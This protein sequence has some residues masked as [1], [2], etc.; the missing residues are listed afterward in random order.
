MVIRLSRF[1]AAMTALVVLSIVLACSS[2]DK[3]DGEAVDGNLTVFPKSPPPEHLV[4]YDARDEDLALQYLLV[5]LQG[6]VNRSEPHIYLDTSPYGVGDTVDHEDF[7]L[8]EMANHFGITY[9]TVSSAEELM[10]R[11]ADEVSGIVITDPEM[12][13]TLNTAVM[14]AGQKDALIAAPELLDW[15][16]SWHLPVHDDL[17]GVWGSNEDLYR[18]AFENLWPGCTREILAYSWPGRPMPLD[19]W[20]AHKVFIIGLNLHIAGERALL[21]EIYAATPRN[22]PVLGW[23]VD[24]LL[25]V[26]LLSQYGKFLDASDHSANFSVRSGLE[27]LPLP[28]PQTPPRRSLENKIYLAFGYTDG[29]N[30]SYINRNMFNM[31]QDP[32]RGSVPLGWELNVAIYD[33]APE[34]LNYYYRTATP[35]DCFIG[36]PSGIGYMYPNLYP[37]ALMDEFLRFS[38]IYY[39]R[40]GYRHAWLINDDLTLSDE[41][42][43]RYDGAMALDGIFIDYWDNGDKGWYAASCGIPVVRSQYIYLIGPEQIPWILDDARIAKTWLYPDVPMFVFIGVNAWVTPPSLLKE[44]AEELEEDFDLVRPDVMMDLMARA[45]DEGQL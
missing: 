22:I 13:H 33:L 4:V 19:Y 34:Q 40:C 30:I 45:R 14:L 20:I 41:I 11:F 25:G 12:P 27:P 17:R 2:S 32:E 18:W 10:D 15:L 6:V 31:W 43:C 9:E 28:A 16:S 1:S 42:A 21:E 26:A 38:D 44:I 37:E 5:S 8:E 24:E 35:N 36:P 29:D 23:V 3:P 39:R 7:W